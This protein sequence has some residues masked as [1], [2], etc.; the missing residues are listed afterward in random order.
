MFWWQAISLSTV[1]IILLWSDHRR[2]KRYAALEKRALDLC[3]RLEAVLAATRQPAAPSSLSRLE[4]RVLGTF[5]ERQRN[6]ARGM[7]NHNHIRL[8][9]ER[10]LD[11]VARVEATPPQRADYVSMFRSVTGRLPSPTQPPLSVPAIEEPKPAST[12]AP[13][14]V[15]ESRWSFLNED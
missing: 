9:Y 7:E 14:P 12:A 6:S 11:G 3:E 5:S 8:Y 15:P 10:L 1:L 13:A 2:H 4:A